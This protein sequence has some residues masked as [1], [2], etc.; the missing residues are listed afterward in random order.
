ML[1]IY[2]P[3]GSRRD[4][5]TTHTQKL[6][7]SWWQS[8]SKDGLP[9]RL[10]GNASIYSFQIIHAAIPVCSSRSRLT[11]FMLT[12]ELNVAATNSISCQRDFCTSPLTSVDE[13]LMQPQ[14]K[15]KSQISAGDKR[16]SSNN[17]TDTDLTH[18]Y[19]TSITSLRRSFSS[20]NNVRNLISTL[21]GRTN[22]CVCWH[23]E[24]GLLFRTPLC[25]QC[26][27]L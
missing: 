9:W 4:L 10:R 11:F 26:C 19:A 8:R 3:S 5:Y 2:K 7:A 13:R 12:L 1:A 22:P 24:T 25:V 14:P 15:R 6:Q 23:Q 20:P 16:R 18:L 21:I 27:W 17:S